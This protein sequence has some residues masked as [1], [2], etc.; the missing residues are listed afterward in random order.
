MVTEAD[1]GLEEQLLVYK[2]WRRCAGASGIVRRCD[3]QLS[4][5]IGQLSHVSVLCRDAGGFRFRLAGSG[6]RDLFACEARGRRVCDIEVC[7]AGAWVDAPAR[8]LEDRR[9]IAGQMRRAD[10]AMHYW[11]RLP[12][13]S[14][15]E[16][17]DEV[18]CHDRI[19]EHGDHR[20]GAEREHRSGRSRQAA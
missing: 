20:S 18:L 16:T 19:V 12:V 10:G 14:G 9:P 2:A 7:E 4:E 17:P 15:G 6:V 1:L 13:S 3:L 11:L 5:F 8:A